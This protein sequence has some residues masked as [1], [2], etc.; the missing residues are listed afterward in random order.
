MTDRAAPKEQAQN[1]PL[2][3][4]GENQD[5]SLTTPSKDTQVKHKLPHTGPLLSLLRPTFYQQQRA[6]QI[7]QNVR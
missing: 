1:T 7:L 5:S 2:R 4:H 6:R 3:H